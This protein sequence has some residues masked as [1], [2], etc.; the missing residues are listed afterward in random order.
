MIVS[1]HAVKIVLYVVKQKTFIRG[2]LVCKHAI[3]ILGDISSNPTLDY[4]VEGIG[5]CL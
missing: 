1:R 4:L 2:L 3:K 5:V